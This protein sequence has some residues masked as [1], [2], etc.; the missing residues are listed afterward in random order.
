MAKLW[1]KNQ[2]PFTVHKFTVFVNHAIGDIAKG[3][4]L[5][6]GFRF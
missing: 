2:H 6:E 1:L 3:R 5:G 4:R